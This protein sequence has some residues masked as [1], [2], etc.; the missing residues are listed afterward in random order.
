MIRNSS[1]LALVH[2]QLA[3][4]VVWK[5]SVEKVFLEFRKVVFAKLRKGV[6]L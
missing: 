6:F 3:E 2:H 5:C 1:K 4:G